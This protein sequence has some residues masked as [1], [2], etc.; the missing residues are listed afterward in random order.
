[1]NLE[2]ESSSCG[3]TIVVR[4]IARKSIMLLFLFV[5]TGG[6]QSSRDYDIHLGKS[7]FSLDQPSWMRTY[8]Q[9][10]LQTTQIGSEYQM[11]GVYTSPEVF[12]SGHPLIRVYDEDEGLQ[13][14]PLTDE[15]PVEDGTL[16]DVRGE[17]VVRERVFEKIRKTQ[18]DNLL[19]PRDF[20]VVL[21]SS[22]FKILA[23]KEYFKIRDYL[24]SQITPKRSQLKLSP[25]PQWVVVWSTPEDKFIVSARMYDLMYE[26]NID[27]AFDGKSKRLKAVYAAEWFKGER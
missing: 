5:L 25:E 23:Q 2:R 15:L 3:E 6:C 19:L 10:L 26:A 16:V 24:Q 8:G 13:Y 7:F 14:L 11:R 20:Q 4:T 17:I 21:A 27:L 9:D 1:M 18:R 22:E 12:S